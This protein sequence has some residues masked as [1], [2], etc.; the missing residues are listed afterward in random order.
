MLPGDLD[1]DDLAALNCLLGGCPIDPGLSVVEDE[2]LAE[3]AD[4]AVY[5]VLPEFVER[6][7]ALEEC[8]CQAVT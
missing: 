4:A 6:L 7:S 5:R 3:G 8:S 2:L 1:E